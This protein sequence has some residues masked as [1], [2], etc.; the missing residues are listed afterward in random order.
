MKDKKT[1]YCALDFLNLTIALYEFISMVIQ[2]IHL[3]V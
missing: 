3:A 1:S 2:N